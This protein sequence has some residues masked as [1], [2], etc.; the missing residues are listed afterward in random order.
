M[1]ARER[2][3]TMM[4]TQQD[5]DF[6]TRLKAL[7]RGETQHQV[8]RRLRISTAKYQRIAQRHQSPDAGFVERLVQ[9]YGV[10]RAEW[11]AL[12]PEPE[13]EPEIPAEVIL[14]HRKGTREVICRQLA[15]ACDQ[16]RRGASGSEIRSAI[17]GALAWVDTL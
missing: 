13:P 3:N 1:L 17:Q 9:A 2:R 14:Q 7:T 4:E 15:A 10:D 8:A 5:T 16:T 11:L 12:L 6:Y